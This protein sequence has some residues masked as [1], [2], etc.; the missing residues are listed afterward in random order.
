M[1]GLNGNIVEQFLPCG[2][3]LRAPLKYREKIYLKKNHC[4]N[5]L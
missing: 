3:D 5:A 4:A 2:E 1:L